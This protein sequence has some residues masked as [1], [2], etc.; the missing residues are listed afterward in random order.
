MAVDD[1]SSLCGRI[2]RYFIAVLHVLRCTFCCYAAW[3]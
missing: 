3:C 1:I 2:F